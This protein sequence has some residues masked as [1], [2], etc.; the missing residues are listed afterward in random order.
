MEFDGVKTGVAFVALILVGTLGMLPLPMTR[1]TIF[2]MVL[3]SMVVFGLVMLWLGI[4][5]GEH[6]ASR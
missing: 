4:K 2:M 3:P 6:R 5:H 1:E